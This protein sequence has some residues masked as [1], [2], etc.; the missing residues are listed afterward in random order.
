[1]KYNKKN[2][3]SIIPQFIRESD[4]EYKQR[5]LVNLINDLKMGLDQIKDYPEIDWYMEMNYN[6]KKCKLVIEWKIK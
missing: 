5:C 2:Y 4:A 6:D 1:M 3:N